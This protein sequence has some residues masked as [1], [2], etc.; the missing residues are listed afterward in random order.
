MVKVRESGEARRMIP[1]HKIQQNTVRIARTTV[2][3]AICS[4]FLRLILLQVIDS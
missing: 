1:Y 3:V 2:N 4:T